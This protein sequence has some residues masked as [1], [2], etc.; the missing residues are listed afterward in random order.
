VRKKILPDWWDDAVTDS[1]AGFA[2]L[3]LRLSQGLGLSLETLLD[4]SAEIA[5]K[6]NP[7]YKFKGG[8]T[9]NRQEIVG[10]ICQRA[11]QIATYAT[12]GDFQRLVGTKP[13]AIRDEIL[14]AGNR[15][16]DLENL[17][18]YCW[19]HGIPV[20]HL[21]NFPTKIRKPHGLVIRV[22]ERPPIVICRKHKQPAWLL[23]DL[24]HE[25]GHLIAGHV[26]PDGLIFDTVISDDAKSDNDIEETIADSNAL[27]LLTGDPNRT[28]RSSSPPPNAAE[29]AGVSKQRGEKENV[30][31][32]HIV[33]NYISGLDRRYQGLGAAALKRLYPH[34]NSAKALQ[35]CVTNHLDFSMLPEEHS[36]FLLRVAQANGSP[37]R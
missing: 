2:E 33:L 8:K 17:S 3:A 6:D 19:Q 21:T 27:A 7:S 1:T 11:A 26:Q 14:A 25:L 37:G 24:A 23:F 10:G 20:L 9:L 31:P 12:T 36:D 32:G 28:Y 16:V 4:D 13:E 29:L 30:Y 22:G 5:P 15:W 35:D 34:A 18:E